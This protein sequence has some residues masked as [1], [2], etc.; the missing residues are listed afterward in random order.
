MNKSVII[1][2]AIT[3]HNYNEL[4]DDVY[5]KQNRNSEEHVNSYQSCKNSLIF[6]EGPTIYETVKRH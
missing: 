5:L 2:Y 4:A 1:K 6:L 3:I